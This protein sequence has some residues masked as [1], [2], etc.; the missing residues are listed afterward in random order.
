M[1]PM[2]II[3]STFAKLE[4]MHKGLRLT[5]EGT[6]NVIIGFG[7]I[8]L[9]KDSLLLGLASPFHHLPNINDVVKNVPGLD[10][11]NLLRSRN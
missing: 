11:A 2:P 9:Q 5:T 1:N 7:K 6:F 8:Y 4:D 10:E 3:L